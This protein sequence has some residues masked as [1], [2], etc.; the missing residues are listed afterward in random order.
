MQPKVPKKIALVSPKA[1]STEKKTQ[2]AEYKTTP[3]RA[4]LHKL[5]RPIEALKDA[6]RAMSARPEWHKPLFRA[7]VV[8]LEQMRSQEAI[9]MFTKGLTLCK[10]GSSESNEF[11]MLLQ[12]ARAAN[13][14]HE[15]MGSEVANPNA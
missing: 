10:M 13:A 2:W 9:A 8:L 11:S 15:Q 5:G 3:K 7:G 4:C 12:K 14:D 6:H 1:R